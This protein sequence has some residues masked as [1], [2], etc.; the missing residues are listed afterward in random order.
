MR[1]RFEQ[2]RAIKDMRILAVMLAEGE[3]ELHQKQHYQPIIKKHDFDGIEH[4]RYHLPYDQIQDHWHPWEKVSSVEFQVILIVAA[5]HIPPVNL[6]ST[7]C[8]QESVHGFSCPFAYCDQV[9]SQWIYQKKKGKLKQP[10]Q[11][12]NGDM[13]CNI[14]SLI[15]SVL[16]SATD[17]S[18]YLLSQNIYEYYKS[19]Y[20]VT[21][22]ER[23][24]KKVVVAK[25]WNFES[26]SFTTEIV[27]YIYRNNIF[28]SYFRSRSGL[29]VQ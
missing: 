22:K 5:F 15:D 14:Y 4:H 10:I 12:S 11:N 16:S 27:P 23:L 18:C 7:N 1:D 28:S 26:D 25:N 9:F 3:K 6:A 29:S 13:N 8:Y 2:T 24:P 19:I 21:I 17:Q 20:R